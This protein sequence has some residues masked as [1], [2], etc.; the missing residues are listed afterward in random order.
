M[1]Q[2]RFLCIVHK[3]RK[4]IGAQIISTSYMGA[5][6]RLVEIGEIASYEER[7]IVDIPYNMTPAE[8]Y[9][10]LDQSG[11]IVTLGFRFSQMDY[12]LVKNCNTNSQIV[13]NNFLCQNGGGDI[14]LVEIIEGKFG[15]YSFTKG[16]E[17]IKQEL[18]Y[19][20]W[21]GGKWR[22]I[23]D[24]V[25]FHHFSGDSTVAS[26]QSGIIHVRDNNHVPYE[27]TLSDQNGNCYLSNEE[28]RIDY[29]EGEL[30][31]YYKKYDKKMGCVAQESY[32]HGKEDSA[33]KTFDDSN[34]SQ[35][36]CKIS[37]IVLWSGYVIDALEFIY[38]GQEEQALKH[39]GTGGYKQSLLMEPDECLVKI[40]GRTARY[41]DGD[42]RV[43]SHIAFYTNKGRVMS[44][45]SE[46]CCSEFESFEFTADKEEQIYALKGRYK[47]F[48]SEI[49]VG[50][51]KYN[52]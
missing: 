36:T 30:V 51:Y 31:P 40:Q 52:L 14:T 34:I 41:V 49:S 39:G 10:Y 27:I 8:S 16:K 42:Q 45:G 19:V 25:F 21:G 11:E 15:S 46:S 5:K 48:V 13:S 17:E 28:R 20:S 9:G 47:E 23:R 26:H 18:S 29:K 37:K 7:I 24:G 50:L 43:V 2:N 32:T 33:Y 4:I 3:K 12:F 1:C 44:G 6:T 35:N 38:A 22:A